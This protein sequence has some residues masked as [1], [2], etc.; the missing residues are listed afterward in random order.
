MRGLALAAI[1]IYQVAISPYISAGACRHEPTCSRYTQQA[2]IK[3]GAIRGTWMG[4]KRIARCR[5]G[6]TH[7]HDPIP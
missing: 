6:G 1:R 5:P 3:H 7:G 2:I 4:A